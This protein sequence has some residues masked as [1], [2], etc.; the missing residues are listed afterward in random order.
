MAEDGEISER[1]PSDAAFAAELGGFRKLGAAFVTELGHLGLG[2]RRDAVP[3]STIVPGHVVVEASHHV[4][5][6]ASMVR[7]FSI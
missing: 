7:I 3:L 5:S 2:R 4:A 1:Q 6:A